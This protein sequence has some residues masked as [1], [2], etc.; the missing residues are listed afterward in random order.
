MGLCW[1]ESI[2]NRFTQLSGTHALRHN[3][4][5]IGATRHRQALTADSYPNQRIQS[6]LET[7]H[8]GLSSR[9]GMPS[10]PGLAQL[11]ALPVCRCWL[12]LGSVGTH[13]AC[14]QRSWDLASS[15]SVDPLRPGPHWMKALAGSGLRPYSRRLREAST[16]L[17][18]S[19]SGVRANDGSRERQERHLGMLRGRPTGRREQREGLATPGGR[20]CHAAYARSSV[21]VPAFAGNGSHRTIGCRQRRRAADR[22]AIWRESRE[23]MGVTRQD[24]MASSS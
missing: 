14:K 4:K 17:A 8:K 22:T 12:C 3:R 11:D 18:S 24:D 23:P 7:V 5:P 9:L 10:C 1:V 16:K 6:P 19:R 20:S 2:G 13:R 15:P 21:R